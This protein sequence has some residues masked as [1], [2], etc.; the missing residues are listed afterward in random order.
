MDSD[1]NSRPPGRSALYELRLALLAGTSGRPVVLPSARSQAPHGDIW[2]EMIRWT[3]MIDRNLL[4]NTFDDTARLL[5][6]KGVAR[7]DLEPIRDLL[8][9][10]KDIIRALDELRA[11]SNRKSAEIGKLYKQGE[12]ARA[13]A[14]KAET[15]ESKDRIKEL[16]GELR[17]V[18]SEAENRLLYVPNLPDENSPEGLS[19]ESN[20]I[21]RVASYDPADYS[22]RTYKPHWDLGDELGIL[23]IERA[24]KL[25]GSMTALFRKEGARLVRALCQYGLD[26][27]RDTYEEI[28]PP[29]FVRTEV[30]HGTGHLPKFES[31]A[32]KLHGEELWLIPTAEVPLTSLHRGEIVD[33]E[34]LPRRYMAHTACFRREAGSAGKDTRGTQR[35]HE[36]HKVELVR[37]CAPEQVQAEF[38]SLVA[39][40]EKPLREL[41][42]PYR[43][44][45]LCGGDL[46]FSSTR[47]WDLE[48]YSPGVDKWLE[49]SSVGIFSDFQARRGNSRF[50]RGKGKKPEFI[51]AL[52]GS[53]I[54][55]PRMW[56]A[57][58]E[59]G[60]EPDGSIRIPGPLVPYMGGMERIGPR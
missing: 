52:N 48:V 31:D 22:G 18:E 13:E 56:A 45:D 32:Y 60:Q 8:V 59:H 10:R 46:T 4:L 17:E 14:L 58:I 15:A 28:V 6:R 35:L 11:E 37:L 42:L 57:I 34:E 20:V 39:D 44:V 50:R 53:A 49:V 41:G 9:R 29:H 19:E 47:I 24:G 26:L 40:A 54:A 5:A 21:L 2:T 12:R 25:S 1:S 36:F 51:H 3:E 27:H 33:F 38:D 16:D 23:D 30:F 43:V 7:G 55:T